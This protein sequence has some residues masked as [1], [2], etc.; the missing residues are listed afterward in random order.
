MPSSD[1]VHG[2]ARA[3]AA[4]LKHAV[5]AE[6]WHRVVALVESHA[7]E[8]MLH[9]PFDAL[10]PAVL[11]VPLEVATTSITVLAI[12]DMW[13]RVPDRLLLAAT[14][15]AVNS[16]NPAEITIGDREIRLVKGGLWLIAA[17]RI[18]GWFDEARDY[19]GRLLTV[20]DAA[21]RVRP[22]E[23]AAIYPTLHL[24][25]G[26]ARLL[27]GDVVGSLSA[28]REAYMWAADNPHDYLESDAAGK[29][30]L[31]YAIIGDYRR[32][33]E[34][35]TRHRSAPLGQVFLGRHVHSTGATAR[36]LAAVDRLDLAEAEAASSELL[37]TDA[38]RELFWACVAY[39]HAQHALVTGTF[40]SGL[41]EVRR[42]RALHR[43]DLGHG[44]MAGPL[45]AAVESD[46]L[47]ALGRG[48]QARA[49][50]YGPYRDHHLLRVSQARLALLTGQPDEAL[51]LATDSAWERRTFARSRVE[52]LLIHAVAAYRIGDAPAAQAALTRAVDA[53]RFSGTLRPFR[54]VPLDDLHTLAVGIPAAE[55]MLASPALQGRRQ[56]FTEDVALISL[57]PREQQ[58]LECL[59]GDLTRQQIANSLHISLNTIKVQLRGLFRK[60]D[61]ESRADAVAR[62]RAYGLI[63]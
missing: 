29:T 39:G 43:D 63:R 28:L 41:D 10:R 42:A 47:L 8:Y 17:L 35:L 54:T 2:P 49:V 11:S 23:V 3:D 40:A 53:A 18:R 55:E 48:N 61:V 57:T 37:S 9:D 58:L 20:L 7:R 33:D 36:L 22:T 16:D 14:R 34:W 60:L 27:V 21:R 4:E 12:R 13:L 52:M 6:D 31:T 26:I 44:A 15:I 50:A 1:S 62:G 19:A 5:E 59:A 30:A 38:H 45:L 56:I 32:V 25:A 51:R 46:L 24:Q